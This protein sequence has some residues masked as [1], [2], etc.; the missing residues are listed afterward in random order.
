MTHKDNVELPEEAK[1]HQNKGS[2]HSKG[3][4]DTQKDTHKQAATQGQQH[5]KNRATKGH[6]DTQKPTS[7]VVTSS[8]DTGVISG[9]RAVAV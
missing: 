4:K 1:A 5:K 7:Q 8:G 6:K 3:Q 9:C 2:Q